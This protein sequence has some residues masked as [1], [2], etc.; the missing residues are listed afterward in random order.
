MTFISVLITLPLQTIISHIKLQMLLEQCVLEKSDIMD[1]AFSPPA[2]QVSNSSFE[3]ILM[4]SLM[5]NLK[6]GSLAPHILS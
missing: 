4:L 6:K 5:F 1:F 2:R 3:A